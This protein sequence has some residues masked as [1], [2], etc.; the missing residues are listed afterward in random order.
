MIFFYNGNDMVVIG[1]NEE[2]ELMQINS[3]IK[4]LKE[5]KCYELAEMYGMHL[6]DKHRKE[7][8]DN[9]FNPKVLRLDE[10]FTVT[11]SY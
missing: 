1:T 10:C 5:L 2:V 7:Y 9:Y 4:R 3:S 6:I 8:W 11:V